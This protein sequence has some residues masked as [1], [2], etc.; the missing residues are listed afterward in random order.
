[1]LKEWTQKWQYGPLRAPAATWSL[2][3]ADNIHKRAVVVL[4][5][6]WEQF[7]LYSSVNTNVSEKSWTKIL[8][9]V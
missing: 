6:F 1:M 7:Y 4:K 2:S 9:N 5:I 3:E 8:D